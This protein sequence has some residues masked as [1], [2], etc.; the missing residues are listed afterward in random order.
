MRGPLALSAELAAR[1]VDRAHAEAALSEFDVPAQVAAA[2]RLVERLL[3]P[4]GMQMPSE[5]PVL[6]YREMLNAVG[7]KLLR[8]GFSSGVVMA[9]CRAVLAEAPQPDED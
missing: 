1:G 7:P 6:G 9:A 5:R 3:A 4:P 2:T 8:R